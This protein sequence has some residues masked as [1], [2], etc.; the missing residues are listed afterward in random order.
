MAG[1]VTRAPMLDLRSLNPD[2]AEVAPARE[3]R[4]ASAQARKPRWRRHVD[5]TTCERDDAAAEVESMMAMNEY[6]RS[7]GRMFPTWSEVL[8]VLKGLGYEKVGDPAPDLPC[9][10]MMSNPRAPRGRRD[11][12]RHPGIAAPRTMDTLASRTIGPAATPA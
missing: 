8:E 7:S 11:D 6:K 12:L 5:P 9:P 1:L 10:A 3:E 4:A 2:S